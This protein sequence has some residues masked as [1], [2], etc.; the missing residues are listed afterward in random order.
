MT[1]S[2]V[3]VHRTPS[4]NNQPPNKHQTTFNN[5]K[6]PCRYCAYLYFQLRS[7]ADLFQGEESDDEP[8]MSLMGAMLLLATITGI[9]A[10]CSECVVVFYCVL[11]YPASV[12][13]VVC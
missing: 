3:C 8:S 6:R 10:V 13:R 7:H 1:L 12:V 4:G 9:V 11:L 5:N 2:W